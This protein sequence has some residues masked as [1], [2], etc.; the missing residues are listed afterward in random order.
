MKR[1]SEMLK[2]TLTIECD[3][4]GQQF[5]DNEAAAKEHDQSKHEHWNRLIDVLKKIEI[6]RYSSGQGHLLYELGTI[7]GIRIYSASNHWYLQ[8]TFHPFFEPDG[9]SKGDKEIDYDLGVS[10]DNA[11]THIDDF[12]TDGKM[13]G[14]DDI[15]IIDTPVHILAVRAELTKLEL[16][17]S[18]LLKS[19]LFKEQTKPRTIEH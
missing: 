5:G 1:R 8:Y 19:S 9:V 11:R 16:D 18:A 10:E 12:L 13:P 7:K 3:I 6:V 2:K 14:R 4:C 17:I 15:L